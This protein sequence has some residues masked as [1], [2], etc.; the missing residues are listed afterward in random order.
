MHDDFFDLGGD[1]LNATGL[2][3]QLRATFGVDLRLA[4]L[5]ERPTIAGVSEVVDMLVL[6][7]RRPDSQAGSAQREEFNL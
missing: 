3:A 1:S 4:S 6:T 5:F 2:V 7:S